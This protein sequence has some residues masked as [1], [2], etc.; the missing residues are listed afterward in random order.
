MF[1]VLRVRS[2]T[3]FNMFHILYINLE[4]NILKRPNK[5]TWI[6]KCNFITNVILLHL[7]SL[8]S[9]GHLCGHIHDDYKNTNIIINEI[10][11][12]CGVIV[13]VSCSHHT[14]DGHMSCQNMLVITT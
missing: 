7:Y 14:K 6:H 13:I 10:T 11:P 9:F 8:P 4:Y 3:T 2:I 5:C 12:C 1:T